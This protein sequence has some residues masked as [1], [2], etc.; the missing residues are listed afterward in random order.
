MGSGQ[1]KIGPKR[2][3]TAIISDERAK[4][5]A[6]GKALSIIDTIHRANSSLSLKELA[7]RLG[8]NKSTIHH[9]VSTLAEHGFLSQEPSTR[10]YKIGLHLVEV[11]QDYLSHS[12]VRVAA[13]P[14]LERLARDFG[15]TVHLAVLEGNDLV[16]LD[17]A[18]LLSQGGLSGD[19]L[20]EICACPHST[21]AGKV[22]LAQDPWERAEEIL[23]RYG[24]TAPTRYTITDWGQLREELAQVKRQGVAFDFQE[25]ELGM[26]SVAAPVFCRDGRCVGALGIAGPLTRLTMERLENALKP[27]VV[28]AALQISQALG[29]HIGK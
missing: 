7:E 10:R 4:L 18:V 5:N 15:E 28:A 11:A 22:L 1:Q 13:R 19:S 3:A 25:H 26:H 27:A 12:E 23:S 9:L 2:G 17:K 29:C 8:M 14:F 6:V 16:L 21:A 24:L 20:I